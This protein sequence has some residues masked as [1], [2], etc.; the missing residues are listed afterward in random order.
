MPIRLRATGEVITEDTLRTRFTSNVVPTP[1]TPQWLDEFGADPVFEGPQ[2]SPNQYQYVVAAGVELID[3]KWYTKYTLGP[4]FTEYTDA[5]GNVVTV[6]QQIA[7]WQA[8]KD[9]EIAAA[10]L[11]AKKQERQ[12]AV[13]AI[14]VTVDN[15][16]FDGDETS[17]T[18]MARAI[19]VMQASSVPTI[20][21]VLHDNT[22]ATVTVTQLTQALAAAGAEQ[23]R[24]WVEPYVEV[25]A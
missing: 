23:A 17:Q 12:R 7:N 6:E 11:Q 14:T 1:L 9:M 5:D 8:Q 22:V 19:V 15:M 10:Q 18:R 20:N 25:S 21:W 24:L 13:E 2:P 16:V 4:D 3:G